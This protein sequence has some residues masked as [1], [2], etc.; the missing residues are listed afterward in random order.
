MG[1]PGGQGNKH[2]H[3]PSHTQP[4]FLNNYHIP[5]LNDNFFNQYTTLPGQGFVFKHAPPQGPQNFNLPIPT[6]DLTRNLVPPPYKFNQEKDKLK[7]KFVFKPK[8]VQ[9]NADTIDIQKSKPVIQHSN[10]VPQSLDLQTAVPPSFEPKPVQQQQHQQ[11][12]QQQHRQEQQQQQQND[13]EKTVELQVT[14]EKLKVFHNAIPTFDNFHNDFV[15]Y[16]TNYRASERPP[17]LPTYEVTEGKYWQ[18]TP[19]YISQFSTRIPEK[20]RIPQP[21]LKPPQPQVDISETPF[22]PTPYKTENLQPTLA[23]QSEVSTVFS[24]ISLKQKQQNR[25]TA[26]PNFYDVKEV[27]TH[28]PI[29]GQPISFEINPTTEVPDNEIPTLSEKPRDV[30]IVEDAQT[31]ILPTTTEINRVRLKQRRRR[32]GARPRP[33]TEDPETVMPDNFQAE[34]N[35]DSASGN[36]VIKPYRQRRPIRY[37]TTTPTPIKENTQQSINRDIYRKRPNQRLRYR[38]STTTEEPATTAE[39]LAQETPN[40]SEVPIDRS[41]EMQE[42]IEGNENEQKEYNDNTEE[43]T[44]NLEHESRKTYSSIYRPSYEEQ[45]YSSYRVSSTTEE[46]PTTNLHTPENEIERSTPY[47]ERYASETEGETTLATTT[48][49]TTTTTEPTTTKS[50]RIRGRPIKYDS[51]RPRFS[52][53]DYKQRLNQYSSTSTSTTQSPKSSTETSRFRFPNRF[54]RPYTTTQASNDEDDSAVIKQKSDIETNEAIIT[55]KPVKAINTRLRPFGRQRSTTEASTTQK[56]SI[57][58]NIFSNL[59]RPT[60]VSLRKRIYNRQKNSTSEA[61]TTT[62]EATEDVSEDP[63]N[64]DAELSEVVETTIPYSNQVQEETSTQFDFK[65]TSEYTEENYVPSSTQNEMESEEVTTT[66]NDILRS[67]TILHRV[68]ELTS[69]AQKDYETPG[70]FKNV[71]PTSRRV[72]SYFTISTEDPVLPLAKIF[73]NISDKDQDKS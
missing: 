14:K 41:S 70:L 21:E 17:P 16:K 47:P 55:D 34:K 45:E 1:I 7:N 2:Y 29:I 48:V 58:P 46:V 71:P 15:N 13:K 64:N 8:E 28:Y 5:S 50:H 53:K 24:K 25:Q 38:T 30:L 9:A 65:K 12:Q 33:T 66:T 61:A 11:Q 51:N 3:F 27:S 20:I 60:P 26:N 59:K 67:D 39:A 18:E 54:R 10:Y 49:S 35:T 62:T 44:Y 68:S 4:E 31:T 52:V 19:S 69:S 32:P 37:R 56:V 23:T 72:P 36:V 40:T 57:R 63:E 6:D 22:L 73:A 42:D 43:Q